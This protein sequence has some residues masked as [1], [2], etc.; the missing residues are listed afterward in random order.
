M[1]SGTT[2]EQTLDRYELLQRLADPDEA[3]EPI[4][5]NN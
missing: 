4:F 3:I 2:F 1:S 5:D